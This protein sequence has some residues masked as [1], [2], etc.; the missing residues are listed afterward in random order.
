MPSLRLVGVELAHAGQSPILSDLDLHLAP[1]WTGV[2]GANGA[3]KTT[4]LELACGRRAPSRGRVVR[5]PDDLQVIVCPQEVGALAA[6]VAALAVADDGVARRWRGRLGCEPAALARWSTLS[7]GERKRWQ[8]AAALAAE[9]DV[10]ALDEPTNHLDRA[11]RDA[12][13]AALRGYRGVGLVVAHDRALLDELCATTLRVHGGRVTAYAGGYQAARAQWQAE[14]DARRAARADAAAELRRVERRLDAARRTEAAASRQVSTSARMRSRYDSD[15]RSL[16]AT[17]LAA[18]AAAG[19]GRTVRRLNRAAAEAADDV[20]AITVERERGGALFV[21]WEPP[22]R[23]W[24]AALDGVDLRAG[25]TLLARDVRR[26]VAR[27]SRIWITGDNGAG[28]TTLVRALVAAAAVPPDRLLWLPQEPAAGEGAAIQATIRAARPDLRGRIGQL[29][30]ALGLDV[31]AAL[32]SPA[33]SPGEVRKLTIALGLARAAWLVVL[34]EPTNHLD[35]PS[36]ERLEAA[37]ADYPGALV[38]V[39][40]D[41]QLAGRVTSERWDLSAAR[42][43]SGRRPAADGGGRVRT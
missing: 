4:L 26:A 15:A 22:H 39:S 13:V 14:A 33:P 18:W 41:A 43:A 7:P 21:D 29:A 9:P 10:L 28:K 23:R 20:A 24:L 27:D 11:G 19:A 32:G 40:H 25:D 42:P 37:L 30:A 1:G 6:D 35:L 17:T 3:G 12:L 38:L 8:L 31:A 36:I 5:D 16:G 34:D 2:V